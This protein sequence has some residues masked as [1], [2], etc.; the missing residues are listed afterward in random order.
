MDLQSYVIHGNPSSGNP[1]SGDPHQENHYA[2]AAIINKQIRQIHKQK[3]ISGSSIRC[4]AW[5]SIM[6]DFLLLGSTIKDNSYC[7]DPQQT[8]PIGNPRQW[9]KRGALQN[10][11]MTSTTVKTNWAL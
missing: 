5:S 2:A 11:K 3:H 7:E 6:R 8:M 4:H 1:C 9:P 10:S